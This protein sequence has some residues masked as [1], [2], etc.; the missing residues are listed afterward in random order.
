MES[1]GHDHPLFMSN[2]DG[3]KSHTWGETH[4]AE[5]RSEPAQVVQKQPVG[6]AWSAVNQFD[7]GQND[8]ISRP[9]VWLPYEKVL[10]GSITVDILTLISSCVNGEC[11]PRGP[12]GSSPRPI[13]GPP[14]SPPR[15]S[16][17]R[18]D[19]R[20]RP[21]AR[22]GVH[23]EKALLARITMPVPAPESDSVTRKPCSRGPP[24][25][26]PRPIPAP[27]PESPPLEDRRAPPYAQFGLRHD[28]ALFARIAGLVPPSPRGIPGQRKTRK[29]A[30]KF[31]PGGRRTRSLRGAKSEDR[32]LPPRKGVPH[33]KKN[34][35]K[36]PPRTPALKKSRSA[37][38]ESQGTLGYVVSG[39]EGTS[40]LVEGLLAPM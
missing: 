17:S 36:L 6:M 35:P 40:T 27:S 4:A 9:R 15:R 32:G 2:I 38:G 34:N 23:H 12:P 3:N 20:A 24:C 10:L 25:L 37:F 16:P 5:H 33:A 14:R 29:R 22:F 39:M 1:E 8:E 28:K 21:H 7:F 11:C 30:Q 31:D 19:R 26:S 18:E 13:R